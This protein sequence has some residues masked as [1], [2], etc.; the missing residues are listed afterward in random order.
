MISRDA[1][2]IKRHRNPLGILARIVVYPVMGWGVWR[3]R[4]ELVAAGLACE[5]SLWTVM[6]PVEK[7][8]GFLEQA[9]ETELEWLNAPAGP[10]KTLSF[11]LLAAFPTLVVTGLWTRSRRVLA[12]SA[13][14]ISAFGLLMRRVAA[15]VDS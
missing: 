8:F 5:A 10:Q 1:T 14:V 12:G 9:I 3:H 2:A 6:P 13:G 11:V 7:T 4:L 15:E